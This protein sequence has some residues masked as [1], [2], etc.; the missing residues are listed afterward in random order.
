MALALSAIAR[1]GELVL[2]EVMDGM[3]EPSATRSPEMPWT[4]SDGSTTAAGSEAGPI[5]HV[6]TGWKIELEMRRK[7]L[8][9]NE[10]ERESDNLRVSRGW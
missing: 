2:P 10:R 6:P 9:A 3:I 1:I 5:M 7:Q 4:R 8:L